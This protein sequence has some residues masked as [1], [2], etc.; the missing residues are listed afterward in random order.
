MVDSLIYLFHLHLIKIICLG[1][2]LGQLNRVV[3]MHIG[4]K[5]GE[6]KEE[7]Y[8]FKYTMIS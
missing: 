1:A 5:G 6:K 2:G 7:D 3:S 8:L 4:W